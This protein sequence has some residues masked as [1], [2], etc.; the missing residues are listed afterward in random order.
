LAGHS[1][2]FKTRCTMLVPEILAWLGETESGMR[3][4]YIAAD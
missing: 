2:Y 4:E 3:D 1:S